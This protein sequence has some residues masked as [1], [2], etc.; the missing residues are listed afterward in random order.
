VA[1]LKDLETRVRDADLAR[2]R[3]VECE[4]LLAK[5]DE[6]V[7]ELMRRLADETVHDNE[8]VHKTAR[9]PVWPIP[10]GAMRCGPAGAGG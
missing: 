2:V 4:G 3:D 5:V 7:A 1:L 6:C 10:L 8:S 9:R